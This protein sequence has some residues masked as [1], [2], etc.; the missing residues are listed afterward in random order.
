[1]LFDP[2][3]TLGKVA[4]LS[5]TSLNKNLWPVGP[6]P[7]TV[8]SAFGLPEAIKVKS[9]KP[10]FTPEI[11]IASTP[12]GKLMVGKP[13]KLSGTSVGRWSLDALA[14]PPPPCASFHVVTRLFPLVLTPVSEQ[15]HKM[16]PSVMG[17]VVG[18]LRLLLD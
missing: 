6:V 5:P 10:R 3:D 11:C 16:R 13:P 12:V 14:R 4:L 18:I 2:T 9:V 1:M 7:P 8:R 17:G 15:S